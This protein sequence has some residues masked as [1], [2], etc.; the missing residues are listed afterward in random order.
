MIFKSLD[1]NVGWG[2]FNSAAIA[3][4]GGFEFM[5]SLIVEEVPI[6]TDD[7]RVFLGLV[8]CLVGFDEIAGF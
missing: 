1:S 3:A 6:Y 8:D 5:Q 2:E 4:Y 7:L